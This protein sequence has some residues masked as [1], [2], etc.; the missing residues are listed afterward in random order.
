[1]ISARRK[2]QNNSSPRW[3]L[4]T[5]RVEKTNGP[6]Q[7][8]LKSLQNGAYQN[9]ETRASDVEIMRPWGMGRVGVGVK[10]EGKI[11]ALG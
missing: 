3:Y 11:L 8:N 1:M 7:P 10:A 2:I 6:M 4:K 5:Q 9:C